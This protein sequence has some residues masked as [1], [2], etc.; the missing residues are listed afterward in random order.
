MRVL[1]DLKSFLPK[2]LEKKK[3]VLLSPV[4]SNEEKAINSNPQ[5]TQSLLIHETN[6]IRTK[7]RK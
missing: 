2:V 6:K 4:S 7:R 1:E 5:T 3:D